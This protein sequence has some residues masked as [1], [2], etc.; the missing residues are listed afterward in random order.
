MG[1]LTFLIFQPFKYVWELLKVI[2]QHIIWLFFSALV[3]NSRA[4]GSYESC[5]E[6]LLI[7]HPKMS[8]VFFLL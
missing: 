8:E 3:E 7:Y 1:L 4:Y 5:K 6:K 2:S